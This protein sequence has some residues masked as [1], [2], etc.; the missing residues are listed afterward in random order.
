MYGIVVRTP[1]RRRGERVLL[2]DEDGTTR[3]YLT[4]G[5]LYASRWETREQAEH[6]AAVIRD[7]IP[8]C[9]VRVAY[10]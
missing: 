8:D 4:R 6:A 7:V 9:V 1:G 2:R 3:L 5:R 10:A